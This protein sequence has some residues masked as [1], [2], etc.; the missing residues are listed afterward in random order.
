MGKLAYLFPGQGSQV[1]GMGRDICAHSPAALK[2]FD[3]GDTYLGTKI[4]TLCFYGPEESL[5]QT[6]VAQPALFVTSVAVLKALEEAGARRPDAVA[7]HS[8]GEYAA[9]VASGALAYLDGLHLVE[10]RAQEMQ[11]AAEASPGIMAAVLG[12]SGADAAAACAEAQD[13][14]AGV[15]QAA[16]FNCP[17]QVVISGSAEGVAKASEIAKAKGA[18]RVISLNVSGAFHSSLMSDAVHGMTVVLGSTPMAH[19]SVPVI[20]NLTA[21]YESDPDEIKQNLAAQIDHSVRWEESVNRLVADG[22]D[23]FV[24]VGPGAVL[25]GL[26]KRLA[27]TATVYSVADQAGVA[28]VVSAIASA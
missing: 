13:S 26:M 4:S 5:R 27:P 25:A 6:V 17:G 2:V 11:R 9:L 19:A 14:G 22:F 7:G 1:V 8:I 18:K 12:L 10:R 16:N 20:A 21:D 23:T 28:E 3:E 24:E 15:V